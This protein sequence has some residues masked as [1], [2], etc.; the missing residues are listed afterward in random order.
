MWLPVG[1]WAVGIVRT[2]ELLCYSLPIWGAQ[3]HDVRFRQKVE[4]R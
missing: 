3:V 4:V 2:S 1:T